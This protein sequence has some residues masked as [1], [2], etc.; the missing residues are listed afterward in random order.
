MLKRLL[1]ACGIRSYSVIGRG[2]TTAGTTLT[3]KRLIENNLTVLVKND[4]LR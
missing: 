3:I 1:V 2:A 4:I